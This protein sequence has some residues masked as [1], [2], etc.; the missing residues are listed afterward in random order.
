[1]DAKLKGLFDERAT[2]IEASRSIMRKAETES[3][4][5]TDDER[6]QADAHID[7]AIGHPRRFHYEQACIG[8]ELQTQSMF[9]TIPNEWNWIYI[10]GA[11][12]QVYGMHF[13]GLQGSSR[14][15]H[16]RKYLT[17]HLVQSRVRWGIRK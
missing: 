17:T 12:T 16:L 14:A 1:M 5:L 9:T 10:F 2:E 13:A 11:S 15:V 7:K 6:R 3:R 8:Y 4:S